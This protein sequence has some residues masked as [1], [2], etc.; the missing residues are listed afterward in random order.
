MTNSSGSRT[1]TV[2]VLDLHF[3]GLPGAIASYLIPHPHGAILIE[4]GPSTTLTHLQA[5]LQ[6]HG[7]RLEDITDVLVTHIHLD[8]AGAA[9]HLARRGAQIHVH[10]A[11][12]PH[13]ID[14]EKL[15]VSAARIYGDQMERLW[16]EVLPV[17]AEQVSLL[18]D[19][20]VFEV[21]LVRIRAIDTPG[22]AGH[23]HAYLFEDLLFSGDIGGVRLAGPAH[24]RLPMPPPEFH[25]ELWRANLNKLRRFEFTRIAPTHFGIF[26]DPAWHLGALEHALEEIDAWMT[27]VM[28]S[29]PPYERLN[30]TFLDWTRQRSLAQGISESQIEILE[31]ANPSWMSSQGIQRYW[32]KFRQPQPPAVAG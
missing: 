25:L 19:G 17:P 31:A 10:P 28:P 11:G 32:R 29:D 12:A 27:A 23:H 16:G 7:L 22:H 18:Q 9:G 14:P 4:T 5:G 15:L 24:L 6:S 1:A 2:S 20:D 21:G 26:T 8:H 3:L 13:L 30:Q